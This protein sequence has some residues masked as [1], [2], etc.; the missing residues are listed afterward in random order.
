MGGGGS[1]QSE[2]A[3]KFKALKPSTITEFTQGKGEKSTT[4][5]GSKKLFLLV[6]MSQ[7][8]SKGDIRLKIS[9]FGRK[10]GVGLSCTLCEF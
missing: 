7:P 8:P 2:G 6:G 1:K 10:T 5:G 3:K 4:V 9:P